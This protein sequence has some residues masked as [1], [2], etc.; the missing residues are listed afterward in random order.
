V[1]AQS[2][3]G[4][5]EGCPYGGPPQRMRRTALDP[6]PVAPLYWLHPMSTGGAVAVVNGAGSA[7]FAAAASWYYYFRRPV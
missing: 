3:Q 6:A 5:H 1:G 4:T 7:T 2:L